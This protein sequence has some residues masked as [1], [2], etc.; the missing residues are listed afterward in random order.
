V[1]ADKWTLTM[2]WAGLTHFVLPIAVAGATSFAAFIFL[3]PTKIGE[4]LVAHHLEAKIGG[5]K[6]EQATELGRLQARPSEGSGHSLERARVFWPSPTCGRL[7]SM[8]TSL[9]GAAL[10]ISA[11]DRVAVYSFNRRAHLV[12]LAGNLVIAALTLLDKQSVFVPE[13]LATSFEEMLNN[14]NGA[15]A[16]QHLKSEIED[17]RE[18]VK[19]EQSMT[20]LGAKGKQ[21]FQELRDAVCARLL[22]AL[23]AD[24][25]ID[26]A[27]G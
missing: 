4:R 12:F 7:P 20:L 27:A 16:E 21:A 9:R 5:L 22:R 2:T 6:H 23:R 8:H 17:N 25:P 26:K 10:P 19:A 11:S 3:L 14:L 1:T 18:R 15:H 13:D 24:Q